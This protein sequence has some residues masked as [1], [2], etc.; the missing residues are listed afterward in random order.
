MDKYHLAQESGRAEA[1]LSWL[2]GAGPRLKVNMAFGLPDRINKMI[3]NRIQVRC[4]AQEGK[5]IAFS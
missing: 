4:S 2:L 5:K 3:K 1:P